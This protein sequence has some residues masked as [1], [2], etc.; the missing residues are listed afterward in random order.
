MMMMMWQEEGQQT[1]EK[2]LVQFFILF[3]H[4]H[5]HTLALSFAS[6]QMKALI[7]LIVGLLVLVHS[8]LSV[9][10]RMVWRGDSG[11]FGV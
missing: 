9:V 10:L 6:D 5:T 1:T 11:W 2:Q 7:V 3:T 8:A 4:T